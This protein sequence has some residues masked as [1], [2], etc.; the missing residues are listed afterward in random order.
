ML[1]KK[2]EKGD[3]SDTFI[4]MHT[5]LVSVP[6]IGRSLLG[7]AEYD[8]LNKWLKPGEHAILIAGRGKYSFKGSGYVRGGIF[9][10]IQ[11]I[12]GDNSVRFFDRQ[13][14]RVGQIAANGASSFT[15][16]DLFKIP[17]DIGFDP[18]KAFRLQLLVQ[19][20]FL[21]HHKSAPRVNIRMYY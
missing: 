7:K 8:N 12:Q 1:Q 14:R 15:E 19:S 2:P 6:T 5:A 21:P 16:M 11:L 20:K 13:H 3:G 17:A 18:T 4:E 10:R 9:D